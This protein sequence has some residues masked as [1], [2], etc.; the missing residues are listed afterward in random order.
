MTTMEPTATHSSELTA[1]SPAQKLSAWIEAQLSA[2]GYELVAL[3]IVNHREKTLRLYIDCPQGVTLDDCACV[4]QKLDEP[5]EQSDVMNGIFQ[6]AYDLEV[7]SPGVDRPLQKTVDFSRFAGQIARIQTARA[8]T[9]HET[10]HAEYSAKNPKQK[11][12]YGILRGFEAEHHA[13]LLGASPEDGTRKIKHETLIKIP[14]ELIVKAHLE[15]TLDLPEET[16]TKKK[17]GA[18][19]P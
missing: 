11:N 3:E 6:G 7:S 15:P 2:L 19:K 18:Q 16:K 9:A 8:L 17:N 13:V 12:F 10:N 5:L 1:H 4:S 14:L